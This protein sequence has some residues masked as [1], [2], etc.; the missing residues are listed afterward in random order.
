MIC[1]F[2]YCLEFGYV[3]E[4]MTLEEWATLI[5]DRLLAEPLKFFQYLFYPFFLWKVCMDFIKL[6]LLV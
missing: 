4:S 1:S 3:W 6:M 5:A 2:K